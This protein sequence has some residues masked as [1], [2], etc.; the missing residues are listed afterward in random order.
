ML[1]FSPPS[2]TNTCFSVRVTGFLQRSQR[3]S[4]LCHRKTPPVIIYFDNRETMLIFSFPELPLICRKSYIY[5]LNAAHFAGWQSTCSLLCTH[6][7]IDL[8]GWKF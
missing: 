1:S 5:C 6:S 2:D 4:L 3:G 8:P 7:R